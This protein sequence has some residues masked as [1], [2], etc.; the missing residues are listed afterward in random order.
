[1]AGDTTQEPIPVEHLADLRTSIDVL[2]AALI[3]L[4]TERFRLTE[5]VGLLKASNGIAPEDKARE[6]QQLARY[7]S[8]AAQHGATPDVIV[9]VMS[10]ALH[11]VK[12]RHESLQRPRTRKPQ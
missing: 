4:L 3:A 7:R 11:H 12:A 8:L 10:R 2:D 1:M 5:K 9:D 6:A